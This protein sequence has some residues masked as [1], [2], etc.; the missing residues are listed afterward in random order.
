MKKFLLF[1]LLLTFTVFQACQEEKA[2]TIEDAVNYFNDNQFEKALTTVDN[3]LNDNPQDYF[4]WTIKGR[5][6]FALNK[7][8][9]GIEAMNKAIELNPDYFQAFAYRGTMYKEIS[10]NEKA[11]EDINKA[12]ENDNKNLDLIRIQANTLYS[13]GKNE[14]AI[15]KFDKLITL[16]D[17]DEESFVYRAILNKRLRN[18]D[19]VLADLD[20]AIEIN[21]DYNFAYE[22]RADFFTYSL[23]DNFEQAVKDYTKIITTFDENIPANNQAF[24]YNNR[25]FAKYQAKDFESAIEDINQSIE[26]FPENAYAF[27]NRALVHLASANKEAMCADL[28]KAK[29]LG[30][31]EKYGQ[32]VN[33]LL[34]T[35]CE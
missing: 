1:T 17:N 15:G 23:A 33:K 35:N 2:I 31:E 5:S 27:R 6:L 24:V 8:L 7:P 3:V 20:K 32:E 11:L 16:N 13:L 29:A 22:A 12:I 30:F 4:A 28:A 26:L 9:E 25:G 18:Y 14:E 34:A 10:E 19:A 21:P